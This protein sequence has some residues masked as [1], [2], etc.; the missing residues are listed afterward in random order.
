M[1]DF[2][3]AVFRGVNPNTHKKRAILLVSVGQIYHEG[4]KL[5]AAI[6]LIN[7]SDFEEC[8]IMLADSLQRYNYFNDLSEAEAY[9]LA[10]NLGEQWI[11]RNSDILNKLVMRHQIIRWDSHYQYD[12]FC[13]LYRDQLISDYHSDINT[14]NAIDETINSYLSRQDKLDSKMSYDVISKNC[15][16]YVI[17]ECPILMPLWASQGYDFIIYPKKM[18]AA[19]R[20]TY[21][22]F[23]LPQYPEKVTWLS[24]R[25][26]GK[27]E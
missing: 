24:L 14:K 22:K 2:Y 12:S 20:M 21:E 9:Q 19:M 11:E 15:F 10:I 18:T 5:L 6:D 17:E 26:R 1:S 8:T 13:K 7:R 23:V 4:A 3:R 25:L 16:K 27:S